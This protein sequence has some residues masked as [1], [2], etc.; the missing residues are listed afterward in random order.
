MINRILDLI[1][2]ILFCAISFQFLVSIM[3]RTDKPDKKPDKEY[4]IEASTKLGEHG[5]IYIVNIND[6]I[7]V[8]IY[9]NQQN[10][11]LIQLK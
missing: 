1:V 4:K 9:K 11:N 8:L 6:S 7:D 5:N 10:S 2:F 3:D